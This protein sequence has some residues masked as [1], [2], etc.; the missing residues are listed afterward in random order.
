MTQCRGE[1]ANESDWKSILIVTKSRE[2][3]FICDSEF[4]KHVNLV[5]E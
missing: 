5:A 2:H 3:A 4:P 1:L